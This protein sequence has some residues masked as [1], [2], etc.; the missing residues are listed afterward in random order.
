MRAITR[1]LT[2]IV[3]D[4]R[5]AQAALMNAPPSSRANRVLRQRLER[6]AQELAARTG[7]TLT[8]GPL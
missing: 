7:G 2:E 6:L 4:V 3:R 1:T 5:A 8:A